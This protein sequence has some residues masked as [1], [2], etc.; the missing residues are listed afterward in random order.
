MDNI[1]AQENL[2]WFD[3]SG[4]ESTIQVDVEEFDDEYAAY[5]FDPEEFYE[6]RDDDEISPRTIGKK[7]AGKI[8]HSRK[9]RT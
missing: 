4:V 9:P 1:Y 5:A 6:L 2:E 8:A 3:D 7:S